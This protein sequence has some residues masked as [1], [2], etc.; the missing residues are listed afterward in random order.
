MAG[1]QIDRPLMTPRKRENPYR[2][3]VNVFELLYLRLF[4]RN[5]NCNCTTASFHHGQCSSDHETTKPLKVDRRL[6]RL[7]R[8]FVY[9]RAGLRGCRWSRFELDRLAYTHCDRID[10]RGHGSR[11]L[12]DPFHVCYQRSAK[13]AAVEI[14]EELSNLR[15]NADLVPLTTWTRYV[16]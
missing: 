13:Y 1:V 5:S 6:T 16:C 2:M 10:Q 4:G 11:G 7:F 9:T 8:L 15:R 14:A 3:A 12:F